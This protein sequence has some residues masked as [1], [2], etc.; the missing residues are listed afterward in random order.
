MVWPERGPPRWRCVARLFLVLVALMQGG[1]AVPSDIGNE[2]FAGLVKGDRLV[3]GHCEPAIHEPVF[4]CPVPQPAEP[5]C[6]NWATCILIAVVAFLLGYLIGKAS[7]TPRPSPASL[8][9]TIRAAAA[10]SITAAATRGE[11]VAELMLERQRD[12]I[13]AAVT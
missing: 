13:I 1:F 3:L 2:N 10:P 11:T 9:A 4:E 6:L 7:V 12:A 8:A 5:D